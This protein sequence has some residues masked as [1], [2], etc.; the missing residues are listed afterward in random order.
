MA[1]KDN[2]SDDFKCR[3]LYYN[4]NMLL[5]L[6]II[7]RLYKEYRYI[8]YGNN[9]N[10]SNLYIYNQGGFIWKT[11]FEKVQNYKAARFDEQLT[12]ILSKATRIAV[13]TWALAAK[14]TGRHYRR[15][16][17]RHHRVCRTRLSSQKLKISMIMLS[18]W[19]GRYYWGWG[20]KRWWKINYGTRFS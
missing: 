19:D 6:N 15:L 1:L 4:I 3:G 14:G 11:I 5:T 2:R 10:I 17:L 9:V 16:R 13:H 8:F 18:L 7:I 12:V 20:W